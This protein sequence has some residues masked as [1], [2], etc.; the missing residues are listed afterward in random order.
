MGIPFPMPRPST[1]HKNQLVD[2]V[3]SGETAQGSPAVPTE[4]TAFRFSKQSGTITESTTTAYARKF[5]LLHIRTKLLRKHEQMGL[6]RGYTLDNT[7]TA[8]ELRGELTS[9][10]QS[11]DTSSSVEELQVHTSINTHTHTHT[12]THTVCCLPL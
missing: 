6:I 5:S 1:F 9:F 12:H 7:K 2:M 11:T 4:V 8:E 3:N 10:G